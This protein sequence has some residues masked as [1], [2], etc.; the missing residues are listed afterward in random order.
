VG[1]LQT[2][3]ALGRKKIIY[4]EHRVVLVKSG[5]QSH[6][7][8]FE[9]D[10]GDDDDDLANIAETSERDF[11]AM[12]D[13]PFT[14]HP[15]QVELSE[16][17]Y[18]GGPDI[19]QCAVEDE[20]GSGG[21]AAP[22]SKATKRRMVEECDL[23]SV[24]RKRQRVEKME[25]KDD[26]DLVSVGE[27]R[28]K[29]RK[30]QKELIQSKMKKKIRV[31]PGRLWKLRSS[32]K[33]ISMREVNMIWTDPMR[34]RVSL[35]A[36][37]ALEWRFAGSEYFSSEAA[38]MNTAGL[39]LGDGVVVVLSDMGDLGVEEFNMAFL[40]SPGVDPKLVPDGWVKNHYGQIVWGLDS[41]ERRLDMQVLTPSA[42]MDRLKYR[43]D[44]EMDRGERSILRRVLE[45][46]ESAAVPMV[47]CV[48]QVSSTRLVLT[49]GWYSMPSTIQLGTPLHKLVERGKVAEGM[50]LITQG[51]EIVGPQADEACP[52][53]ECEGRELKIHLNSTRRVR[54]P[55]KLGMTR[56]MMVSLS[57]LVVGGGNTAMLKVVIARVYPL[58]YFVKEKERSR[59]VGEKEW[60]K[61][62]RN[63]GKDKSMEEVFSQVQKEVMEEEKSLLK[64]QKRKR[65]TEKELANLECGEELL[66]ILSGCEDPVLLGMLSKH[67]LK[68]M[69]E[70]RMEK[71]EEIRKKI[72]EKVSL[73]VGNRPADATPV[74]KVR[75]EDKSGGVCSGLVTVWRPGQVWVDMQEGKSVGLTG[76]QV[77]RVDG[78]TVHLTM[79]KHAQVEELVNQTVSSTRIISELDAVCQP[80]F[81]PAFNELDLVV[82]VLDVGLAKEGSFQTIT[83]TDASMA[84]VKLLVWGGVAGAGVHDLQPGQVV[85]CKNLEWRSSSISSWPLPSIYMTEHSVLSLHPRD[86]MHSLAVQQ[87]QHTVKTTQFMVQAQEKLSRQMNR[88]HSR[89]PTPPT[90]PCSSSSAAPTNTSRQSRYPTPSTAPSTSTPPTISA[91]TQ[92]T[93]STS[94][95]S[96]LAKLDAYTTNLNRQGCKLPP[97]TA[98]LP[99]PSPKVMT[100]YKPP[101]GSQSVREDDEVNISSQEMEEYAMEM[102]DQ[103][104]M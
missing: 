46:D 44:R 25:L 86:Q 42:V 48:S 94:T 63:N 65:V 37:T 26:Y 97:V 39:A 83:L 14:C 98:P 13:E 23:G 47:L 7:D 50:K 53:L 66:E 55:M 36:T 30:K 49:D 77:N 5:E 2:V 10:W 69:E 67:Q 72:A 6:D 78:H 70:A 84:S 28:E 3:T 91:W 24:M 89:Y 81:R 29:S 95:S 62:Q 21:F 8:Q 73:K 15:Y 80:G 90:T 76:A 58:M 41:L 85:S 52:P 93:L 102:M 74:L 104:D 17:A 11:M 61:M 96:R 59:F 38:E 75:V 35:T 88:R 40:C 82:V 92:A 1:R 33:R 101:K 103:L 34:S 60:E 31:M 12:Q 4:P 71:Q 22:F 68:A 64:G 87:L 54:W 56:P 9:A 16:T 79:G 18:S 57:S 32:N 20:E 19:L 99:P 51:A 27:G 100:P 43:Y 45:K